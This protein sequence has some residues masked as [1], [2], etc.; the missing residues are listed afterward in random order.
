MAGNNTNSNTSAPQEY[1]LIPAVSDGVTQLRISENRY[2][3]VS[4]WDTKVR[5]YDLLANVLKTSYQ[6]KAGVLDCCFSDKYHV[7]SGGIDKTIKLFEVNS[8]VEQTIGN[9]ERPV[10]CLEYSPV[11]NC[12]ISGSWD[13]NIKLWDSRANNSCIGTYK[14][15]D[16]IF[17]MSLCNEKLVV[18]TAGRHVHIYDLR[19]MDEPLQRRES[20]LKFQT[21][22]IK[23]FPNG[24]GYTLS[25]IEGRVAV[26][27]FDPSSEMQA[28]KY[29]FKCHRVTQNGVD[30]VYPVNAMSFHEQHGT[31]ATGGCDGMVNVWDPDNKKRLCQLHKYP[32]SISALAFSED[33]TTLAIASSYT[34]EEGEKDH[35]SDQIFIRAISDNEVKP[36]MKGNQS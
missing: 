21:R 1:E 14:Q 34:F 24:A 12:L 19:H 33:G 36:K 22:A 35:P 15:P 6:H 2:L 17:A 20:S 27:Y 26:E 29:A 23:C 4:S 32:T 16:K 7:Y 8:S 10:R 5:I 28:K 18:G 31:F 11:T 13:S 30:T 3:L 9:H 25:S